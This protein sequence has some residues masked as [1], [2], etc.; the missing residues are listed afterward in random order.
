MIITDID[1]LLDKIQ[2]ILIEA[3]RVIRN[4]NLAIGSHINRMRLERFLN[5]TKTNWRKNKWNATQRIF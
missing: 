2:N 5:S 1:D 3:V 4:L